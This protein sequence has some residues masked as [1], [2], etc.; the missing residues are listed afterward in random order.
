[1]NF[2]NFKYKNLLNI[3]ILIINFDRY[4]FYRNIYIFIIR[5][6]NIFLL[7][8]EKKLYSIIF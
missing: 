1:M 2:F 3:N 6:K 7:R 4:I 5:L 8:D